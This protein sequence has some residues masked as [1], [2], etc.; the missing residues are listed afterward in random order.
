MPQNN[1]YTT[2]SSGT[3][4]QVGTPLCCIPGAI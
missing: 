2:T 3:N 1:G 4:S